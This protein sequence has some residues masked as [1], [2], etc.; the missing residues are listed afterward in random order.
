MT[1]GVDTAVQ[2]RAV[3]KAL[4]KTCGVSQSDLGLLMGSNSNWRPHPP[5]V[6]RPTA[7]GAGSIQWG[8]DLTLDK[9]ASDGRRQLQSEEANW[10]WRHRLD[11]IRGDSLREAALPNV[12]TDAGGPT[13]FESDA[14]GLCTVSGLSKV[15]PPSAFGLATYGGRSGEWCRSWRHRFATDALRRP[16]SFRCASVVEPLGSLPREHQRAN[17]KPS[18]CE[19]RR[20]ILKWRPHGESNPGLSLERAPS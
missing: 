10:A 17:K 14:V 16:I 8:H 12:L 2:F 5:S 4:R 19:T 20:V 6:W 13:G 9:K 3:L 15:A 18:P 7:D 1:Y 11:F